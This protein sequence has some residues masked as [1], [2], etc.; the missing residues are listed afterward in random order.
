MF[1]VGD[2]Y[3]HQLSHK[4]PRDYDILEQHYLLN[5]RHREIALENDIGYRCCEI[6][7]FMLNSIF[8]YFNGNIWIQISLPT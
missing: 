8:W 2:L 7:F 3:L 1:T 6:I 5:I 4:V